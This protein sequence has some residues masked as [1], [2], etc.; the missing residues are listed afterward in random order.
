[1]LVLPTVIVSQEQYKATN[2]ILTKWYEIY[3]KIVLEK[4]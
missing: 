3:E 2:L 1:M 4:G